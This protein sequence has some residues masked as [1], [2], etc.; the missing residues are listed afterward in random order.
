MGAVLAVAPHPDDETL[1]CGG[2][3]LN[4]RERGDDL[5]WLIVTRAWEPKYPSGAVQQ[6]AQQVHAVKAAYPFAGTEW[7]EFQTTRL[8]TVPMNDLIDR[9]REVISRIRPEVVYL[10]SPCDVHSDH[11][12]VFDAAMAVMKPFYLRSLGI[13]RVLACEIPSETDAGPAAVR[14]GFTPQ[15]FSDISGTL[16]RKLAI[17]KLFKSEVQAEPLPRSLSAI[18]ALARHR[19]ATAGMEYAE[20]FMVV[21]EV[22]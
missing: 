6:Q 19:G 21:R 4:H 10:P 17:M 5:H 14:G 18:R 2:T 11:R 12:L 13:R 20:A 8:D 15:V 22:C 3:L 1:G 16:E 9:F 7:L